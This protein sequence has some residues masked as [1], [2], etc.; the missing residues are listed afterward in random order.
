VANCWTR[1]IYGL[2]ALCPRKSEPLTENMIK[3]VEP[4]L[5]AADGAYA[6]GSEDLPYRDA[7]GV[8]DSIG[9]RSPKASYAY[10]AMTHDEA[11]RP[12]DAGDGR[13]PSKYAF[14]AYPVHA[15]P[16]PTYI[17]NEGR[18]IWCKETR[19]ARVTRW[20]ADP[21]AEGWRKLD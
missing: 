21:A 19:G 18:T 9:A 5:A 11:G 17:V 20:P 16:M 3:L 2:Y 8:R 13:H 14:C 4:S 1:D 15:T 12:Y 10:I 7:V 6:W